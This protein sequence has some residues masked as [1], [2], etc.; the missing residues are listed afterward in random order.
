MHVRTVGP[1]LSNV[2]HVC[3]ACLRGQDPHSAGYTMHVRTVGGGE[4]GG[5]CVNT[6][7]K[8]IP[9]ACAHVDSC[10][11][12]E[13]ALPFPPPCARSQAPGSRGG[14]SRSR[15]PVG[16]RGRSLSRSRSPV[17]GRSPS[18]SR[19]PVPK[20][21]RSPTPSRSPV[22]SRSLSRSPRRRCARTLPD[23]Q[24]ARGSLRT[25]HSFGFRLRVMADTCPRTSLSRSPPRRR[26]R[27]LPRARG[28]ACYACPQSNCADKLQSPG[29]HGALSLLQRVRDMH[30]LD[31]HAPDQPTL[32]RAP[33][34]PSTVR[35]RVRTLSI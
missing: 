12:S 35:A 14:R 16:R 29:F 33:S 18:R 27:N 30:R 5:T 24:C 8:H 19:S 6:G 9:P 11:G 25:S 15:S 17:R 28:Q 23:L 26:A 4:E 7:R 22:R 32:A 31:W 13:H 1:A 10:A 21:R 20:R 34:A 3:V 2:H